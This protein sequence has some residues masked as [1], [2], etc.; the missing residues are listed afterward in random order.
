MW[1]VLPITLL[2]MVAGMFDKVYNRLNSS[3][4]VLVPEWTMKNPKYHKLYRECCQIRNGLRRLRS[5]ILRH[6]SDIK[7][8]HNRIKGWRGRLRVSKD[9]LAKSARVGPIET[10]P[11]P[12]EASDL[13][14]LTC[15]ECD[16]IVDQIRLATGEPF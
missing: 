14:S 2:L 4:E 10:G 8:F 1:K 6:G 5:D 9:N 11:L 16:F 7:D 12:E 15:S 3:M 13:L